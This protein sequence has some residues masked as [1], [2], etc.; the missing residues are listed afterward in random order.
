MAEKERA[1]RHALLYLGGLG[2][3]FVVLQQAL[4]EPDAFCQSSEG[5]ILIHRVA[6]S[7]L[8]IGHPDG[9]E[10]QGGK[11]FP[12]LAWPA[13]DQR[14]VQDG[15]FQLFMEKVAKPSFSRVQT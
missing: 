2:L 3:E 9:G 4:V 6:G 13:I 15:L 7:I 14:A 8:G 5:D 10:P 12:I 1:G 11:L